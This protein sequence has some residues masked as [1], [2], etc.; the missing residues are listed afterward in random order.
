MY[1]PFLVQLVVI[2]R[3][4]LSCG[5]CN[6]YDDSSDPV[7]FDELCRRIDRIYELGAWS[8]EFT[9]GEPLEHPRLVELVRYA[10]Q[11]GFYQIGR[12]SNGYLWNERMVHALNDAG[13]DRRQVSVDGVH[14]N[15][16]TKKVLKPLRKKLETIAKHA[17][18]Q[19]TLNGVIG[20]A[21]AGEAMEV[22]A[23]AQ[24]TGIR[25]RIQLVHDGHGQLALSPEQANEYAAIK[26][27]IG[28][29]FARAVDYRDKLMTEG[30]APFKCRAGSRYLYVDEHG[31]VRWCSQ[32]RDR[33]GVALG[34]YSFSDLRRQFATKKD[35]SAACTVG[36]V[37]NSSAPDRWRGQ[38][39]AQPEAPLVQLRTKQS[40]A[41]E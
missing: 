8:I 9:G 14:P 3:C 6:E 18:F 24:A 1:S 7:P 4:N 15:D 23:F 17:R 39:H 12:S 30:A 2:R 32:T 16:V 13:L 41:N 11:K 20:S 21:P 22:V 40:P 28:R 35:C 5:Y 27:M 37:R 29:R 10:R 31:M 33:W 19:V 26:A 36:C 25:A 38:P 34:D